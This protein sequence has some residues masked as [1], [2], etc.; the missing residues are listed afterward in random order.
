MLSYNIHSATGVAKG[1]GNKGAI[2]PPPL[3]VFFILF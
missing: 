1:R 2:A 3:A